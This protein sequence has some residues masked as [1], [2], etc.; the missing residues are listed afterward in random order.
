[1]S[2]NQ[3][4]GDFNPRK[5]SSQELKGLT[6]HKGT[7]L[8]RKVCQTPYSMGLTQIP[9]PIEKAAENIKSLRLAINAKCFDCMGCGFDGHPANEIRNCEIS[10]CSLWP[11]RPYKPKDTKRESKNTKDIV[12]N[13]ADS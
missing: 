10:D 12:F 9:T 5:D 1:M 4:I 8:N 7:G 3:E 6:P 13:G 11:V 2:N